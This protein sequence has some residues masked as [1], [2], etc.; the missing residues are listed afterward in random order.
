MT[1]PLPH[2]AAARK[3]ERPESI[4]VA[5]SVL[6]DHLL[7]SSEQRTPIR[8]ECSTLLRSCGQ[9]FPVDQGSAGDLV[10]LPVHALLPNPRPR[11]TRIRGAGIAQLVQ[12][13]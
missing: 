10:L 7:L 11:G 8:Q 12:S 13:G 4:Y 6:T 2:V 3:H 1:R 5:L 9:T